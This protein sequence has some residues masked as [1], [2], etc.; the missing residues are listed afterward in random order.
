MSTVFTKSS[1]NSWKQ[2]LKSKKRL[3][4]IIKVLRKYEIAK[5]EA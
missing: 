4:I 5:A 1:E 2:S 3:C